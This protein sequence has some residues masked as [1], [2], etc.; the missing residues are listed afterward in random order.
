MGLNMAQNAGPWGAA[1]A[2]AASPPPPPPAAKAWHVA[3]NG[4][5][6]GPFG[7]NDLAALVSSGA[8]TRATQV[9]TA[10]QDGWKAAGDTELARL[11]AM[12]PPPPP[13]AV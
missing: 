13:P 9:W 4:A 1:P 12:V 3:E 6:K 2:A 10:G 7:E 5:T 11:F 8:L